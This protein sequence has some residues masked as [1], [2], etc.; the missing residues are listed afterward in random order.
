MLS[1]VKVLVV[2]DYA[3]W[4]HF[5]SL[6]LAIKPDVQIVGQATNGLTALQKVVELKPDVVILDIGLPDVNGIQV[7][8]QILELVPKVRILFL[9][10]NTAPETV[11][12]ALLTGAQAYVVKSFA[13]RDLL[14]ALDALLLDCY[15]VSAGAASSRLMDNPLFGRRFTD[16]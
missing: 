7:A 3:P 2:D 14:P 4:V 10:E 16:A 8:K 9:S 13:A 12:A 15:F 6:A 11:R 5:V 1:T